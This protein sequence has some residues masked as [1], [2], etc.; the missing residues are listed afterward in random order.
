LFV[1]GVVSYFISFFLLPS[2]SFFFSPLALWLIHLHLPRSCGGA[3]LLYLALFF[4]AILFAVSWYSGW[5]LVV[6][7]VSS[8]PV[9]FALIPASYRVTHCYRC[10]R[11]LN[12]AEFPRCACCGWLACPCGA[13]GCGYRKWY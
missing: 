9:L 6:Y 5:V 3:L 8:I 13:C 10:K 1:S 11:S 7:L 4:F 12:S 2:S